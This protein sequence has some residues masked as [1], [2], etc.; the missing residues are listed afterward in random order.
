MKK[1]LCSFAVILFAM[2]VSA[3]NA[4]KSG[5][6]PEF[7]LKAFVSTYHGSY[8]VMAGARVGDNVF[9]LG[10]GLGLEYWDAYPADVRKIPVYGFYR[11]YVPL[12]Q[13]RRFMLFGEATLGGECVYKITGTNVDGSEIEHTPYW[14]WRTTL[15]PGIALRL[16]KHFNIYLAPTAEILPSSKE[17]NGGL[18]AGFTVGF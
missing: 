8:E 3:Q 15:S 5:W 14:K 13:K 6:S 11:S 12:D 10:S 17:V 16:F 18:T 7:S 9:G 1:V 4:D 2:A